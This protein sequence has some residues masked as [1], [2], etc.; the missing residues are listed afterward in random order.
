MGAVAELAVQGLGYVREGQAHLLLRG[1]KLGL[2]VPSCLLCLSTLLGTFGWSQALCYIYFSCVS[3]F[4]RGG[5]RGFLMPFA[6]CFEVNTVQKRF[7]LISKARIWKT[8]P[9]VSIAW[10]HW[11]LQHLTM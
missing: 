10:H 6:F 5:G 3:H 9:L 7:H 1:W 2:Q 8:G 11:P 4:L